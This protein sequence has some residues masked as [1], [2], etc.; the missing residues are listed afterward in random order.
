MEV[1]QEND[2]EGVKAV[3]AQGEG[4]NTT[5]QGGTTG[6]HTFKNIQWFMMKTTFVRLDG[7]SWRGTQQ[8]GLA[9][10]HPAR[11]GP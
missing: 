1:P 5:G 3:L 9:A 6:L 8:P 11:P 7:C 2:R 4:V 10:A